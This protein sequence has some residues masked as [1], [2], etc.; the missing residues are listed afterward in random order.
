FFHL[1]QNL[2]LA[3][4]H[5]IQAGSHPEEVPNRL[6]L[7]VF[8]KV[9]LVVRG[10]QPK[11]L[12][13]EARQIS[14]AVSPLRQHFHP[15]TARRNQPFIHPSIQRVYSSTRYTAHIKIDNRILGS[16]KFTRP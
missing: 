10:T 6:P 12:A 8:I 2:R 5:R 14:S 9:R 3:Q 16:A 4:H 11:I 7:P 13:Q 1:S 15:I